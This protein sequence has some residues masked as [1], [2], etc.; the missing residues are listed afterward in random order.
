MHVPIIVDFADL[1]FEEDGARFF[2]DVERSIA[3]T[4]HHEY[5]TGVRDYYTGDQTEPFHSGQV[6]EKSWA[7]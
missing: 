7:F 1:V 6:C 3:L 4:P 2:A 5:L